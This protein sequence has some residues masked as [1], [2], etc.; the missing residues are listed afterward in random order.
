[1]KI[2]YIDCPAGISGDMFVAALIDA[3]LNPDVLEKELKKLPLKGYSIEIGRERRQA[4]E[5]TRFK[6]KTTERHPHRK[7]SDI[8][9]LLTESTLHRDVKEKSLEMFRTLAE[10]EAKVHGIAPEDVEFHEV[11]A[12]DSIVDIVAAC[13]GMRELSPDRVYGSKVPTGSG[14]VNTMHGL[15][16]IPTP[17][18]LELLK[19]IPL[20]STTIEKELTTPTG[21]LI[22]KTFVDEF[23]PIPEMTPERTGYGIGGWRLK[24]IPNILRI[25]MGTT[26]EQKDALIVMETNMDDASPQLCGYLMDRL[27]KEGALDVFFAPIMMKKN[28]PAT[29]LTVLAERKKKD[30]LM[31]LIFR[32]STSIGIRYYPVERRC[33]ERR[34]ER[35]DTPYGSIRVKVALLGGRCVNIQPEYED[36]KKIATRSSIP[37]KT[38]MEE[39]RRVALSVVEG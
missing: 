6:V 38:V 26:D 8:R 17:A 13:I 36:C 2:L 20:A 3:G 37:L 21:A 19:G 32:E 11:G 35:V 24:E 18:T 33:L 25:V 22:L 16:P 14:W 15:L 4:I 31:E 39:A 27:L 9:R 7:F 30:H 23:G 29:L 12:V 10:A 5:G 34:I 1:M 28:R